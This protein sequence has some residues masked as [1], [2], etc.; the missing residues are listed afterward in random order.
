MER[1]AGS[2]FQSLAIFRFFSFA[3]GVGLLYSLDQPDTITPGVIVVMVTGG[4]TIVRVVLRFNPANY[5]VVISLAAVVSD[6]V[7]S[8]ALV[9]L[10]GGLDSR[11]LIYSLAPILTLSLLM[12]ARLAV[13]VALASGLSVA[14]AYVAGNLGLGDYP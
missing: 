9:L 3:M 14:G 13:T 2:V 5:G 12:D 8:L 4:Y 10:T 11:F 7:L 1:Y 6:L